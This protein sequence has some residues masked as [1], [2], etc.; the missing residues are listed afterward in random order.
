MLPGRPGDQAGAYRETGADIAAFCRSFAPDDPIRGFPL[1]VIVDDSA[2]AA[3]SLRNFIWVTFTRSDPAA[4]IDGIDSFIEKKHWGC[5][6]P[7]VIDARIKPHHAPPLVDD[8]AIERR[9]DR[10][11]L[12]GRA[13]SRGVLNVRGGDPIRRKR[14]RHLSASETA[15]VLRCRDAIEMAGVDPGDQLVAHQIAGEPGSFDSSSQTHNERRAGGPGDP[16]MALEAVEIRRETGQAAA[17]RLRPSVR[18]LC[19]QGCRPP[20]KGC[21][22]SPGRRR[23]SRPAGGPPTEPNRSSRFA[24]LCSPRVPRRF[25]DPGRESGRGSAAGDVC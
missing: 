2:F 17:R 15:A 3:A 25:S 16:T 19:R 20:S 22:G 7:L 24:S 12:A 21:S 14:S 11:C 10:T 8:P 4:D 13:A 18:G 5:A 6:G 9:V 23:K 1:I